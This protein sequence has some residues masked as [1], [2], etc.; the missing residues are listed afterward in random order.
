MCWLWARD[1]AGPGAASVDTGRNVS[2]GSLVLLVGLRE[3]E[4]RVL[5]DEQRLLRMVSERFWQKQVEEILAL[6][7]FERALTYHTHDSR[8]SQAGF[9]DL[10]ALRH[11][12]RGV[13]LAVLEL[14]RE[15]GRATVDQEHWLDAW[16]QLA[17]HAGPDVRVVTGVFKPS[18]AERLWKLLQEVE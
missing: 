3:G 12:H 5:T 1:G 4:G 6:C 10:V 7:G 2:H 15:T 8:R 18:D 9:P 16:A 17:V 14:K 13:T 11:D